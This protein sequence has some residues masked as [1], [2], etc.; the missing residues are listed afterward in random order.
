MQHHEDV[1][2]LREQGFRLTRQRILILDVLR[3]HACHLTAEEIFAKVEQLHPTIDRATVYRTLQW[4]HGVG[5]VRKIDVGKDRL[6]YE[7]AEAPSHHH[8]IC[9]SCGREQQIDDHV[10]VVMRAHVLEHYGFDADPEHIAIF[11]RCADCRPADAL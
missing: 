1:Q 2:R 9:R 6:E 4:L 5:L 3:Q 7:S 11:G 10:I 8:L